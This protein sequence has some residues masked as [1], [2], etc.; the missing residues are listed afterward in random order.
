MGNVYRRAR[1]AGMVSDDAPGDEADDAAG[2]SVLSKVC[3]LLHGHNMKIDS[4]HGRDG[5][6]SQLYITGSS[7]DLKS[8]EKQIRRRN[9][10]GW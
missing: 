6:S 2:G 9:R 5:N 8:L 1:R 10:S 3:A 4:A 7:D